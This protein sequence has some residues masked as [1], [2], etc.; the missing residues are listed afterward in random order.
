LPGRYPRASD[1]ARIACRC[2][3]SSVVSGGQIAPPIY[4]RDA[5]I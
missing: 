2:F 5:V 3:D 4:I 1:I